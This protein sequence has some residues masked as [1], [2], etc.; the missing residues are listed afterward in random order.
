MQTPQDGPGLQQVDRL[1]AAEPTGRDDP[2]VPSLQN[3]GRNL[4]ERDKAIRPCFRDATPVGKQHIKCVQTLGELRSNAG[5]TNVLPSAYGI[6]VTV[7][8]PFVIR[9]FLRD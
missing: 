1:P 2:P 5:C 3:L 8:S 7:T 6:I 4:R 9:P